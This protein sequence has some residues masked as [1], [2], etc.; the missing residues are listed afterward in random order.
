MIP[1]NRDL[2]RAKFKS[3]GSTA[4]QAGAFIMGMQALDLSPLYTPFQLGPLRLPNRFVLPGMQRQWCEDGAPLPKLGEYY[5][6][7]VEGGV[8]LVI[9]ESCAVD[10]IS[11]TQRR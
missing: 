4:A 3:G 7:C 9:T 8:G 5:R 11:S 2:G 10:H 6:R 1:A